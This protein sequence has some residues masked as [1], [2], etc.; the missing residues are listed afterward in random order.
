MHGARGR[1]LESAVNATDDSLT[2]AERHRFEP[3]D[4]GILQRA[5]RQ[6]VL[7]LLQLSRRGG[8]KMRRG[9]RRQAAT[10]NWEERHDIRSGA[11]GR[12]QQHEAE[13]A[14][15]AEGSA[16]GQRRH[17]G[18]SAASQA[19]TSTAGH[20]QDQSHSGTTGRWR[21]KDGATMRCL[22]GYS[23]LADEK[24]HCVAGR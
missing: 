3:I 9:M 11:A 2:D 8:N 4:L 18:P 16:S 1:D 21:A 19:A 5:H 23:A 10:D 13:G 14:G 24:M 12:S 20:Y 15:K 6:H 22:L 7:P 17:G